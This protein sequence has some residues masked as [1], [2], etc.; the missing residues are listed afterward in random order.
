MSREGFGVRVG[1]GIQPHWIRP[2]SW[3]TGINRADRDRMWKAAYPAGQDWAFNPT[4]SA[5]SRNAAM[6]K[7][8]CSSRSTSNS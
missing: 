4:V 5:T 1:I 3:L 7:L 2:G 8:M 6:M